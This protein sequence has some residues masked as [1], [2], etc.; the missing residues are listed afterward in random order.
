MRIES[1]NRI[2]Y[3]NNNDNNKN[4]KKN[5]ENE[6]EVID[7]INLKLSKEKERGISNKCK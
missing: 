3:D 4:E 6:T 1:I 5:D 2:Y 7:L